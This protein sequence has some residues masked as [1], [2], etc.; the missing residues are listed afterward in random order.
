MK[1]SE[2]FDVCD[3]LLSR[4]QVK[5]ELSLVVTDYFSAWASRLLVSCGGSWAFG[6]LPGMQSPED[7]VDLVDGGR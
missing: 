5:I 1:G 7:T 2:R 4:S 6:Y 3:D